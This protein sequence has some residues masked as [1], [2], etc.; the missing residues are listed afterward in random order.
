MKHTFQASSSSERDSW[1]AALEAQSAYAKAQKETITGSEGYKSEL[2]KLS[3][4]FLHQVI[5]KQNEKLTSFSQPR[6]R[7][8][9]CQEVHRKQGRG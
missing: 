7:R 2:E 6:R 8:F 4:S 9:G 1:V 3:K 5:R